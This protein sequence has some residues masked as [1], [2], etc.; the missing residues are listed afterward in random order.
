[1]CDER[2]APWNWINSDV[3]DENTSLKIRTNVMNAGVTDLYFPPANLREYYL[4]G[5]ARFIEV[6][7][8]FAP[9]QPM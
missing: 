5:G 1:M 7:Y 4:D 3:M 8:V 6:F 2:D 9:Y